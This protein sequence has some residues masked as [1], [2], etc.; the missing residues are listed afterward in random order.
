[1]L[2]VLFQTSLLLQLFVPPKKAESSFLCFSVALPQSPMC[3]CVSRYALCYPSTTNTPDIPL[4][5]ERVTQRAACLEP[6]LHICAEDITAIATLT[7]AVCRTGG[8]LQ[9]RAT[10]ETYVSAQHIVPSFFSMFW[11]ES[12]DS[13]GSWF[14]LVLALAG[15]SQYSQKPDILRWINLL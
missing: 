6:L 8:T 13:L 11:S 3:V 4:S 5:T 2:G 1:M 9:F 14:V 12:T 10:S 7:I 15:F